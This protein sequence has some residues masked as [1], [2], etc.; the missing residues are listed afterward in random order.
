MREHSNDNR[1]AF[2]TGPHGLLRREDFSLQNMDWLRAE[3]EKRN[4]NALSPEECENSRIKT[5]QEHDPEKDLWVFGYGS[6]MWNPAIDI[7]ESKRARITGWRRSFCLDMLFAR[8]SPKKPGLMLALDKGGG[9]EGVVHCIKAKKIGSETPILWRREMTPRTYRPVWLEAEVE[10]D[11]VQTLAFAVDQDTHLYAGN[12]EPAVQARRIAKA[13][14]DL[15]RN[16][17][18]LYQCAKELRRRDIRDSY[19]EDLAARTRAL[20][21]D[22]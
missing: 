2:F 22:K 18:Y 11:T 15:G 8:G 9:C 17:D 5:L 6:L 7:A 10:G 19:I 1:A 3:L 4:I 13:E 14:G 16:R 12:L 21:Q 20:A